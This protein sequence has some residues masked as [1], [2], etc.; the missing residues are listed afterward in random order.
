M[1][2]VPHPSQRQRLPSE[3]TTTMPLPCQAVHNGDHVANVHDIKKDYEGFIGIVYNKISQTVKQ[4]KSGNRNSLCQM[5]MKL[6]AYGPPHM[7]KQYQMDGVSECRCKTKV[8]LGNLPHT[9]HKYRKNIFPHTM[10]NLRK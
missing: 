6:T 7:L 1:V 3:R 9:M 8:Y 2:V 4:N 5:G 10:H